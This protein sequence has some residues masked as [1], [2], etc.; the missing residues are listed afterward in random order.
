MMI[1]RTPLLFNRL[2]ALPAVLRSV[3]SMPEMADASVSLGINIETHRRSSSGSFVAGAGLRTTT[4]I[5]FSA[6]EST[7]INAIP[8]GLSE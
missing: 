7:I 3:M 8:E 4:T 6:S 2:A 5:E 1:S